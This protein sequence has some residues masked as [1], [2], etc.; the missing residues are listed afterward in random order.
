MIIY[1]NTISEFNKDVLN[2][3]IADKIEQKFRENQYSIHSSSEYRSWENSL[4]CMQMVLNDDEID[5]EIKIAIE[6]QIPQTSKRVDFLITG[7]DE[8]NSDQVIIIELKQWEE[9]HQTSREDLVTTYL[10][11]NIRATTHPSYQAYSYAKT[12]ENFNETVEQ[13]NI[14]LHPC[15]YL[16]NFKEEFRDELDNNLYQNII[17]QAP[18]YL[19]YDAMKLR[20]FIKRFIR[21]ADNGELLYKIENGKIRPS[22]VLQDSLVSMIQGNEEFVMIDEQKV[23]FSTIKKLVENALKKNEKY[24]VIVEGGPGTGKSVIAII[25]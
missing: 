2:G 6:Y 3:M 25:F 14:S 22:K 17:S 10:G 7:K 18:L 11:G 4:R 23:V 19:K 8:K 24:T 9:A 21:K 12:I 16:H 20:E 5:T 15:A 1:N 13:E